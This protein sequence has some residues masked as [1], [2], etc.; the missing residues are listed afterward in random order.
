MTDADET[1]IGHLEESDSQLHEAMY[2]LNLVRLELPRSRT[3]TALDIALDKAADALAKARQILL[4]EL[5]ETVKEVAT[6]GA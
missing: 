3:S 2:L 6:N 1:F 4:T 5:T